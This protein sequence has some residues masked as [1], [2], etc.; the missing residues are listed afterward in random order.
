MNYL[1]LKLLTE[2]P[3]LE[4]E[5]FYQFIKDKRTELISN[6]KDNL[7]KATDSNYSEIT[8]LLKNKKISEAI[9]LLRELSYKEFLKEEAIFNGEVLKSLGNKF[10]TPKEIINKISDYLYK[11]KITSKSQFR[12][13]L[14]ESIGHYSA[15][16]SPYIYA[17]CL[18]NTQS[19]RSRA[20]K[21]FEEIIYFLYDYFNYPFDAQSKV[22]KKSF[23]S[24]G[25]GKLVDSILPS[26][27]AFNQRRD[28]TII[29]T[30][31]TT[32]RERWQEVVEELKR[33]NV[34]K[35]YLLTLDDEF[36]ENKLQQIAKNNI[37]LVVSNSI[38][39]QENL[40]TRKSIISFED[41]FFEEIPE[42]INFWRK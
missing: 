1:D 20:G 31:K 22:G 30:M 28:K 12:E 38:K 8:S 17:L 6:L 37:I 34:P 15:G 9:F 24:L 10:N 35:I 32:L 18:S 2:I 7:K 5:N 42:I 33:L 41:Y 26:S 23:T 39:L 21:G 40:K 27:E 13:N 19:R 36:S 14:L 29:G 3:E 11:T 4:R 25:L 16:I